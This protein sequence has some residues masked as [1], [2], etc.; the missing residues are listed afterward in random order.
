MLRV[1]HHRLFYSSL[2]AHPTLL[3]SHETQCESRNE[4]RKCEPDERGIRLRLSAP[5]YTIGVEIDLA[6]FVLT[7]VDD[8]IINEAAAGLVREFARAGFGAELGC[9]CLY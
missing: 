6:V 2:P 8:D 5:A 9:V 7:G 3:P 1:Q 4:A